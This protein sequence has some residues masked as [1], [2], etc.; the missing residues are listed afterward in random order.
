MAAANLTN[1][2][3]FEANLRCQL[4]IPPNHPLEDIISEDEDPTE[5]EEER[6]LMETEDLTLI[7]RKT[8]ETVY[9]RDQEKE[10]VSP[11]VQG[12]EIRYSDD[13]A[14]TRWWGQIWNR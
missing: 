7:T 6:P 5:D 4:A 13:V 3:R 8:I 1:G 2:W 10:D 9:L 12:L 11:T 14:W